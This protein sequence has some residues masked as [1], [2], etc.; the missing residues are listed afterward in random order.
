MDLNFVITILDRK[1]EREMAA[2]QNTMQISLS[3]TLFGRG[4]A[5][6][7][8]LE[9]YDLEPTSKALVACVVDRERT[10]LLVH[11]AK[12]RLLL[13]VPGNGILL[14]IP[15]KSVCGGRTLAYFTEGARTNG[16]EAGE[17]TFSHELIFVILNQ[18]YTDDV[19]EAARTAGARGG[20]V[21]HAKGTG[22]GLAKKFFGVSLAE[23]KEILL[24]VSDMK[25]KVGI[26]KAIATQSGPDSPA[27]AIS[28]TLPVSEV[29]GVRERIDLK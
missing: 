9:F 25:E 19:M 26:M 11:E 4:T 24:I 13:D 2:I 21:L 17:L 3:L 16:Q 27:G 23:E 12:K 1:R 8:V 29:V 22:A 15:V 14:V 5:S 28:F 6:R 7:E 10:G 20:T 18:G